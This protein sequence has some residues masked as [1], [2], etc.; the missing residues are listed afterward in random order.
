M[1]MWVALMDKATAATRTVLYQGLLVNAVLYEMSS[2]LT[3]TKAA[4]GHPSN[5]SHVIAHM[6]GQKHTGSGFIQ[7]YFM[8]LS[9]KVNM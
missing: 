2:K 4:G 7:D 6:H 8:I 9:E 5:S 3:F 1:E